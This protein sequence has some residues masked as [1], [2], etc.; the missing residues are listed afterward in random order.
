VTIED[1][2]VF[3]RPWKMSMPLY[4]RMEPNT[5]LLEYECA[6]LIERGRATR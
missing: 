1:P 3:S 6:P 5:Q 2:K 4:R